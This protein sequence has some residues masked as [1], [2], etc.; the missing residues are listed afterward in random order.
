MWIKI[1]KA[2]GKYKADEI[3]EV[4]DAV[5][6]AY[7]E[8]NA[9]EESSQAAE[10][11]KNLGL[12][13]FEES[14]KGFTAGLG[15]ILREATTSIQQARLT[16]EPLE[17]QADKT[18][19][20]GDFVNNIVR[21]VSVAD[22]EG[23][24]AAQKRLS[25]DYGCKKKGMEES[26]G[27]TGGYWTTPEEYETAIM[28]EAWAEAIILPGS[29]NVPMG[30]KAQSWPALDQY[31]PP[32]AGDSAEFG[33]VVVSRKGENQPRD[34]TQAG[35]K[36]IKLEANDL[37]ALTQYSRDMQE[38]TPASLSA[39]LTELIGGAIGFRRD[40]EHFYG[41]G[42]GQCQGI[43]KS[44]AMIKVKRKQLGT[45]TYNDVARMLSRLTPAAMKRAVW[46]AHPFYLETFLTMTDGSGRLIYVPTMT[47]SDGPIATN[48]VPRL[49]NLPV[50]YSE[51]AQ[52][53]GT[54]GDFMVVDRKSYLT[55]QR[56]GMEIGL[57]EHF[58][59][60]TDMITIRAKIRD[61]GQSRLLGPLPLG[62][63]SGATD[64]TKQ[65]YVSAFVGLDT[66]VQT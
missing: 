14:I 36:R 1:K 7:I 4:D 58:A 39:M 54:F 56:S 37:T 51:K 15:N 35:A 64:P 23:C 45:V 38:D 43:T 18:K 59:F 8:A 66:T 48:P 16:V 52:P 24:Q 55:G 40:W 3:I 22:L 53:M 10:T 63:G 19:S 31:K 26:Q 28:R 17:Q 2:L 25:E 61:D 42:E 49:A 20:L 6:K 41:S 5:G 32:K 27:T 33:G 12:G 9:A 62:D 11:V 30:A 50:F 65:N 47:T 29:T 34:K 21:A 46:V 57:S 44:K 13:D 60:D